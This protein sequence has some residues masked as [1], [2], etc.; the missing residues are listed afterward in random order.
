MAD[1]FFGATGGSEKSAGLRKSSPA[2]T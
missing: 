2:V 1:K